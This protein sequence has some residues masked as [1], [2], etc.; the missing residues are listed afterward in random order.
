MSGQA[1][2]S[3]VRGRLS[4]DV[5]VISTNPSEVGYNALRAAGVQMMLWAGLLQ[6]LQSS[7]GNDSKAAAL[8]Q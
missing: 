5:G 7:R 2:V 4:S 1:D 6:H 3:R 8:R